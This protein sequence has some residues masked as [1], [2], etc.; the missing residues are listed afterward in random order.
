MLALVPA[1]ERDVQRLRDLREAAAAW[2]RGQGIRQWEPGE[3]SDAQ[4]Q[5]QIDAGEWFVHRSDGGI[6]GG[7]RLLWSDLEVWGDRS[8]DAA[9]VH[10]LVIDRRFAGDGLGGRL[11]DW[12]EQR[13]RHA[14]RS[15][16]RLDC[17]ETNVRLRQYYRGQGY[18]E[19]GRRDPGDGWWPVT[20]FEK[21]V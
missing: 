7:L 6:Q 4:I 3:V 2:M 20:L 5:A 14:G 1:A 21:L 10:G 13:A 11:L 17:V 9:Y 12:A 15:Y 16:L 19:V 8:D 18:R